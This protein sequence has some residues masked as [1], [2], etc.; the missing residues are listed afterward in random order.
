MAAHSQSD[1]HGHIALATYYK[2]LGLLL[3]LTVITVAAAQVDFGA[4]N[5]V[6]AMLI[7]SV[8]AFFVLAFFMHLKYDNK[9][10]IVCFGTAIFFLVLLYF[11]CW[12]DFY[13]RISQGGI[14]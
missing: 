3:V 5:T 11:F 14:L 10:Y 1:G 6:I 4:M 2:I 8:K 7:A 9:L 12:V 13:T